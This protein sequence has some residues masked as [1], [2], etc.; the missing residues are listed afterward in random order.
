MSARGE[1]T[2]RQLGAVMIVA[3][4]M[5]NL[6]T[7]TIAR[8]AGRDPT[9]VADE[10]PPNMNSETKRAAIQFAHDAMRRAG[11]VAVDPKMIEAY[12]ASMV[13]T[14]VP[15][16]SGVWDLM[17]KRRRDLA[18]AIAEAI[19]ATPMPIT[20]DVRLEK[21][22]AVRREWAKWERSPMLVPSAEL[23]S[24]IDELCDAC[25]APAKEGT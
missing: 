24:A 9:W 6:A 13:A 23:I 4:A 8:L 7:R 5:A 15:H 14:S 20:P 19:D 1:A 17:Q 12:K 16:E 11:L 25:G 2:D 22:R 3:K 18:D 21:A 10:W